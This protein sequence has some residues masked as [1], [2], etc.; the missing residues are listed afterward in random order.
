VIANAIIADKLIQRLCAPHGTF[1]DI[2]AHIGSV[3][4]SVRQTDE[5]VKIYAVEADPGKAENLRKKFPFCTLFDVAI[6]EE[7][8]QAE[9]FINNDA[10]GYNTLVP[11]KV[12]NRETI[13]VEV[14]PLDTLLP[15]THIDLIKIDV[16]GAE[17]G[18][19]KGGEALIR[20]SKPTVMFE[21]CGTGV[22]ALGYSAD[23]LWRWFDEMGYIIFTPDRVAHDAPPLSLEPFIDAHYFP[24]RSQN[25]FAVHPDHRIE[26]RDRARD[27]LNIQVN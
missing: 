25:F 26:I 13:T 7:V 21:S 11:G 20:R 19:L 15:E 5:T 24:F 22:N 12:G 3:L 18:A 23:L 14:V 6:G 8:G 17:L 27:I 10:S 2:G 1:L 4:S 16:E 9:F